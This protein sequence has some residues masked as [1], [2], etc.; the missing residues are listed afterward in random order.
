MLEYS[1]FF[2]SLA[3]RSCLRQISRERTMTNPCLTGTRVLDLTRVLAG[4]FCTALLADLGAEVIKIETPGG[5]DYRH[6]PPVADG[7]GGLFRL[8][9]RGKKSV[10]LDLRSDRGR[11]IVGP[12]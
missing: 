4:P 12:A 3:L 2:Y 10:V 9:N 5:D 6:V 7:T 1:S 11:E 8:L